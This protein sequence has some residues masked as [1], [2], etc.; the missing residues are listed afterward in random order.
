MHSPPPV[1][2]LMHKTPDA[3]RCIDGNKL[4]IDL[5]RM[6]KCGTTTLSNYLK[7]HPAIGSVVGPPLND[8]LTKESHF[9][10]GVLGRYSTDKTLLYRTFFPTTLVS[11]WAEVVK[12]VEQVWKAQRCILAVQ[13]L[14]PLSPQHHMTRCPHTTRR[15]AHQPCMCQ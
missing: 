5:L 3:R 7:Q 15:A 14:A 6:Q 4:R 12:G 13:L 9:F 2:T 10:S 11:W 1:A 8:T